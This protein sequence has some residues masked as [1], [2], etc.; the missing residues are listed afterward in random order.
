MSCSSKISD[1][2]HTRRET[3]TPEW[4]RKWKVLSGAFIEKTAE[5]TNVSFAP[6]PCFPDAYSFWSCKT[7]RRGKILLGIVL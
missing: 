2:T 7:C 5:M 3:L 4:C 6:E 1:S